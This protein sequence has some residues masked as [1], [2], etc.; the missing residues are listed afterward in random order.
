MPETL[1]PDEPI[2]VVGLSCRLPGADGPRAF[3]S[4]LRAGE[5][6]VAQ[7][8]PGRW[9]EGPFDP[10][11]APPGTES[12]RW[13]AFLDE[14]DGFDEDFFGIS[15]REAAAMD[16]QQ[17]LALELG[18]EAL[19]DSGLVAA[20][21]RDSSTAVFLGAI[22]DDYALL[23]DRHR[24]EAAYRSATGLHRGIIAN[25][26]SYVLGARG[27]SL[28][29]D[30]GQS[31]S[32]VAV[33][34]ACASLHQGEAELALA[35]GVN[36]NLVAESAFSMARLGALS[37]DGR[38]RTF[39]AGA[40]GFVRGEGGGMVVLKPLSRARADG[41]HVYCVIRGS[42]VNNDGAGKTLATPGAD[43][44]RS[45]LAAAYRRAGAD[46]R[47]VQYVEVHGTGTKVGDP[48]EAAALG[49]VLGA[50]RTHGDPP[51][52]L[53]SAK[54]NVGHLEGAAGIVGLLKTALA[55]DN[56]E[57]PPSLNFTEP[58][59]AIRF[60]D[61]RLRVADTLTP[62]PA[63]DDGE[64]LAGVSS[65]GLGGTNCHVVLASAPRPATEAPRPATEAARVPA[66]TDGA[67]VPWVVTGR[68]RAAL[69]AQAARLAGAVS[70]DDGPLPWDVGRSLAATRT[71]F[72]HR[73]VVFGGGRRELVDE[74]AAL[75]EGGI[76]ARTV[77]GRALDGETAFVF[78]GQ[79]GQWNGMAKGLWEQSPVFRAEAEACVE[80]FA[81][82]LD[83]CLADVLRGA[84]GAPPLDRIDVVQSALFATMVSLAAVWRSLGVAPAAVVGHSQGE[85]AAAYVCGALSL[86][87]AA[88]VVAVRG[89][90]VHRLTGT[91]R[92][93]AVPLPAG[94]VVEFLADRGTDLAVAAV[95][96]PVR[97][98]VAG[99]PGA[100]ER[101]VA[102]YEARGVRARFVRGAEYASHTPLVA[103][104]R[105]E[106]LGLLGDLAPRESAVPFYSTVTGE[107]L[108][109]EAL[110]GDYWY[111]NLARPVRF[112]QAGRALS[113][114]GFT[115]FVEASPHPVLVPAVEETL[116]DAA[117]VTGSL[118]RDQGGWDRMLTSVA[119]AYAHGTPVS[120]AAYCA[121]RGGRRTALPTYAFQRRRHWLDTTLPTATVRPVT[122]GPE[123]EQGRADVTGGPVA[124]LPSVVRATIAAV[125]GHSRPDGVE[126]DRTF[127]DLG[128]DSTNGAELA[129][130]LST[131]AGV[132]LPS[133]LTF[134]HPTPEHV[135]E[136]LRI[137]L[138][139][140]RQD[141]ASDAPAVTSGGARDGHTD[142][143]IAIV[144][145]ACRYPGGSSSP[146]AFWDL[147][148]A[149]REGLS[150]L[151]EDRGWRQDRLFHPDAEHAG[152]TYTRRGGFL[153]DAAGFD[154]D[155]FGISPRE[156]ESMDPQQ[157]LLLETAWEAVERGHGDPRSLRRSAVGVFAG[158]MAQDYG[159]RMHELPGAAEGGFTLTGTSS[160]V[161][162]GRIAY[163]LGLEGPAVTVDTACSSSLVA[164]HLACR[165]LRAGECSMALAGGATVMSTPGIFVEFSRQRGLA[166]DGRCKAFAESADG[167]GWGEGVGL[168]LLE[169]LSDARRRGH[170]VLAVVRGSAVNQDGASNGLTA[171]NGPSQQRVIGQALA[172]AGLSAVDVDVVEAHGTG[173]RLGDPI[174][175]Q[176]LLATYGQGR[177]VERPL[178]LGSLKSNIGHTQAAAGV[179]GVIKAVM[180]MRH[181]VVP[182]TLHVDVPSSR[183]DW[184]SGAVRLVTEEVAWPE[185]GRPRRAAVSSFGISGTNAHLVLEQAPEQAAP[186]G[187]RAARGSAPDRGTAW[188]LSGRSPEAL[189]DQAGRLA[190]WVRA[191][192]GTDHRA[193]AASLSG[194]RTH[195]EHRAV[196]VGQDA[197]TLAA[198][199][200]ALA[201]GREAPG[202]LT[203]RTVPAKGT[204]FVF[205]GQG[206]QWAG[207][208]E[209]LLRESPLFAAEIDACARAL[210]P[211]TDWRLLDVL[212]GLP[213][214]PGL[215]RVDVVQP[216]LFAVMVSLAALWRAHGVRPDAVIGHSQGEIAAAHVAG[217]L[218]LTDAA[219][220]VALRSRA[221]ARVAGTGGMASVPLSEE[222]VRALI[223]D[224]PGLHVAALN[225]PATT[226]VAGDTGALEQ[227]LADCRADGVE[228]RAVAVDY[229]SHT[230]HMN[231]LRDELGT[232]LDGLTPVAA[233]IPFYSTVTGG[234][235]DTTAL[236]GEYWFQNLTR[237]VLF[238][239]TVERLDADGHD[240]YVESSPHPVLVPSIQ[241]ILEEAQGASAVGAGDRDPGTALGT[242]RR[243]SGDWTRF[244]TAL[245]TAHVRGAP[246]TWSRALGSADH[247]GPH[248]DLPTYAF[249][250]ER[251]WL[252]AS[253]GAVDATG[254]GLGTAGHPLLASTTV[255]PDGAWHA[256][257]VLRVDGHPWLAD[258]AVAGTPL[259]PATACLDLALTAGH[260]VGRPDVRELTLHAP[261]LLDPER[262]VHL[263]LTVTA[264]DDGDGNGDGHGDGQ[265]TGPRRF[266]IHSRP[267]SA[268]HDL[269]WTHHAS[270]LL[271]DGP[272][273]AAPR[274]ASRRWPPPGAVRVTADDAYERLAERGYGYGPAFRNLH[275]L[276]RRGDV[277]YAEV[278][279]APETPVTGH[280]VHPALLDAA[281]HALLVAPDGDGGDAPVVLPFSWSGVRLHAT[282]ADTLRVSL[283]PVG[284]GTVRLTATDPAGRPVVTAD[285][286]SLRPLE[287]S[288]TAASSESGGDGIRRSLFRLDWHPL[289]VEEAPGAEA[290]RTTALIGGP[291]AVAPDGTGPADGRYDSLSELTAALA[292]E[293]DEQVPETVVAVVPTPRAAEE[294]ERAAAV[295]LDVLR[296]VQ[297]WLA[298][299]RWVASRLVLAT[300]RAV[301]VEPADPVD[302]A[303]AAVWGLIRSAQAE[304]PGRFLLLD[305]DT[306]DLWTSVPHRLPHAV[307]FGDEPQTAVRAGHLS[308][309]RLA[310]ATGADTLLPPAGDTDWQVEANGSGGTL[311]QVTLTARDDGSAPLGPGEV[312]I[313]VRAAGLNFRDVMVSLGLVPVKAPIGGED[314]GV[315][316]EVGPEVP[317][318]AP[319]DRVMGMFPRG[320]IGPVRVADHRLVGR[321]PEHW[322][323]T[324]A[325]TVPAAFLTAYHCLV[326][327]AATGPGDKVLIHAGT[328]GV[329][330]AAV[331]LA[332]HLGAEVYATA[333]PPKWDTLR[334]LGLDDDHIAS[335]R[336]LDFEDHFRSRSP[337]GLDVVL[338]SLAQE[339]VDASLRLTAPG[340]RFVEMGKTDIR[341]AA[342][343]AAAHPGVAYT[344]FDLLEADPDDIH[345]TLTVLGG[346]FDA[347]A[348]RP[349]PATSW[350]LSR[351]R[352]ALRHLGQ[353]RHTGKVTLDLPPVLDTDGTVLI[354]GG[355]GT[356]GGIVAHHLV[357]RHGVRHLL[358][359]GRRGPDAP[360]ARRLD[361]ELTGLGARVTLAACDIA[362]RTALDA[363]LAAVPAAHPLTAV[364]HAAGALDDAV[365]ENLTPG[366]LRT[367]SRPKA[368]AAWNLHRATEHLDLAAFVLFSSV[369]GTLGNP[370]QANYAAANVFLDALS[371]HRRRLGLPATSLAW[372]LWE[373]ASGMTGHLDAAQRDRVAG[374]TGLGPLA[375]E[376]G[377]RLFDAALRLDQPFLLAAPLDPAAAPDTVPAVLRNLTG[378][379]KRRTA[380]KGTD[381]GDPTAELAALA[382]QEQHHHLLTLVRGHAAAVLGRP[383]ADGILAGRPFKEMGF[384][385]LTA[386]ELRNRLTTATRLRLSPTAV[387]DHPTPTALA[388]HLHVRLA[389]PSGNDDPLRA[390]LGDIE[391]LEA[392]LSGIPPQEAQPV[393]ARL[394][395]LLWQWSPADNPAEPS[396]GDL[397]SA[398]DDEVFAVIDNELGLS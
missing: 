265:G 113:A 257:G 140:A 84:D 167:T 100:V 7:V 377:L 388:T 278:R 185:T 284:P 272:G 371:H 339:F 318:L 303:H 394:E 314:A 274:D 255:L 30:C 235:L 42:A 180:A 355:T 298:D 93:A 393:R 92:M 146:E 220:V 322:S 234:L 133:S 75:A 62:W 376:H 141:D 31:S 4:L 368:E 26:L 66:A 86:D 171:P 363:L 390:V 10:A 293:P 162:S 291:R 290:A 89:R 206:P 22:W 145:M 191:H 226:V 253:E 95:N 270:G 192:P 237:P 55:I 87:D 96:S 37:P 189:R 33:H 320:G 348:L 258:H 337:G 46:P 375:T 196:A 213:G 259:L 24:P 201:A 34:L 47:R 380:A 261:L 254:L 387:F 170:R 215:D 203:G 108:G 209:A 90:A 346:L 282:E 97:T 345:D 221:L 110:D 80:A 286:L 117:A 132:G 366:Q 112:E 302:P 13:G 386:V 249:Q 260:A 41:D 164:I 200:D 310:P 147:L 352:A 18:W 3:W 395:S 285:A 38:C 231:V 23:H 364:V 174:E 356:L 396:G 313:A 139:G 354:T 183:V 297:D 195:F 273:R 335:S 198:G 11:T 107:R 57:I 71:E 292:K 240:L 299:P 243:D 36:L 373:E 317:G 351:T 60:R 122:D 311:D 56:G 232:A 267:E 305:C 301:A 21:L 79:G 197:G 81:P 222:R 94:E 304:N 142:E 367:V 250:H 136:H 277:L 360:D 102:D 27:P 19:E 150:D 28:V 161:A 9:G 63:Q 276:H 252:A 127:K 312:R 241:H 239:S 306:P 251:Y 279:L 225:G 263:H 365:L 244:L 119:E 331:Q 115:R 330:M 15:P 230:P 104:V 16:P 5:D 52:L 188:T 309:A 166:P 169:R 58:N 210:E 25:R 328:G 59:P 224:R 35:G 199:L 358:L 109:T 333:S 6:A 382:P 168:V 316:T 54:T 103:P 344:A 268:A 77:T 308:A 98:V 219:K 14:V 187:P 329:G 374:Q 315:V 12:A 114:A 392:A 229:A 212:R 156:A 153:D 159:P 325:A 186:A 20:A 238:R 321:V 74:L 283:A 214:A 1:H 294:H 64:R 137:V 76:G 281:L 245:G 379:P 32:L 217:A 332:R 378:A 165:S 256:T 135:V 43:A 163:S 340:G 233:D 134:D 70:G 184:S 83:W 176:A 105:D 173:T 29:V 334:A 275:S 131:V 65:F 194:S 262:A 208:A 48:V 78:P 121:E 357:T 218:S 296:L 82:H 128:F 177:S 223:A 178:L 73:A 353:A 347:G 359:A 99:S 211:Y 287:G 144:S 126:L 193:V 341:D 389:P 323:F 155:F 327:V 342:E 39:D 288:L 69:A 50:P 44:Q 202:T 269:P 17:R 172:Q 85:V 120:W 307:L 295:T 361:A 324:D 369:A 157:R 227:L 397:D 116:G 343:V 88:R 242:L 349:L 362:D 2:A 149:G 148:A 248:L 205:P 271:D 160:S 236:T 130:R 154:A 53:G 40:N 8:P 72:R 129:R 326:R 398:T 385:S 143:P 247:D 228:A 384:D 91:G 319:G 111:R 372:G 216:A 289:D 246:V 381:A 124:A 338:N 350:P 181:G 179:A 370:G 391:R 151:P 138:G 106:L 45:V 190:A 175:A 207:M 266:D 125:L 67:T 336:T 68:S 152:T 49:S 61:W 101:L 158:V 300:T 264:S 118:L 383:T 204:V 51:L 280:A 123:R 182:R